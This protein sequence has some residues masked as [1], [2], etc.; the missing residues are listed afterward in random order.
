MLTLSGVLPGTQALL[1]ITDNGADWRVTFDD[2]PFEPRDVANDPA[3]AELGA[4]QTIAGPEAD[5]R[6]HR[7]ALQVPTA[8]PL[9]FFGGVIRTRVETTE[10]VD[11]LT[12]TDNCPLTS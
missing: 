2:Q 7:L 1:C 5:F 9:R 4:S 3:C 11:I 12:D 8:G 10:C 6:S